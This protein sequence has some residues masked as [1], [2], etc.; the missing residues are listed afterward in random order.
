MLGI[1]PNNTGGLG[2]LEKAATVF[3]YKEIEPL[4]QEWIK[5]LNDGLGV[6]VMLQ[7]LRVGVN[8]PKEAAKPARAGF[9]VR[10]YLAIRIS[11]VG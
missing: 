3:V 2:D 7:T 10:V 6:E 9:F 5:A 1:T 11:T 8:E 4:L